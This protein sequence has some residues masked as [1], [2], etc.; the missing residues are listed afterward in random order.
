MK[1]DAL[2]AVGAGRAG[3]RRSVMPRLNLTLR[4]GLVMASM[5]VASFAAVDLESRAQELTGAAVSMARVAIAGR[6]FDLE[7]AVDRPTRQRGLGGRNFIAPYGGMLFAW[8]KPR[9]LAMV[10]RD[11]SIPIDVAFLDEQGRVV[12]LHAMNPEPPRRDDETPFAYESRLPA[13]SSEKPAKFAAEFAGGRLDELGVRA[14]DRF[15]A[16]WQELAARAR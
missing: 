11:C 10:M 7:L 16:D 12:S 2:R 8:A 14:G 3:G 4:V 13:Y 6:N 1:N 5:V 9:D 15:V